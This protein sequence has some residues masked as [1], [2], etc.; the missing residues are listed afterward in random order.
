MSFSVFTGG[1][2]H[3]INAVFGLEQE[4]IAEV[5]LVI[6]VRIS[7]QIE[8]AVLG[9][10][11]KV[12]RGGY[13]NYLRIL[14]GRRFEFIAGVEGIIEFIRRIVDRTSCTDGSILFV[15][16]S[17]R[18]QFA[19]RFVSSTVFGSHPENGMVR[20]FG[21]RTVIL[22]VHHFKVLGNRIIEWHRVADK[23]YLRFIVHREAMLVGRLEVSGCTIP[24]SL[25]QY[26]IHLIT[27]S[28]H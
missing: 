3:V 1:N 20:S 22:Q 4:R 7:F 5:I 14:V 13:H 8:S 26:G 19:E 17:T 6:A 28:A 18:N 12:G 15:T 9:P 21:V 24:V 27:A 23:A 10:R 2:Q 25:S 11:F 16:T